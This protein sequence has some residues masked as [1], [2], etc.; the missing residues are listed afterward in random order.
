MCSIYDLVCTAQRAGRRHACRTWTPAT[1]PSQ[2]CPWRAVS[3]FR[4]YRGTCRRRRRL[5]RSSC[6]RCTLASTRVIVK[7]FRS[8]RCQRTSCCPCRAAQMPRCVSESRR[9]WTYSSRIMWCH[10]L[11]VSSRRGALQVA[12]RGLGGLPR[13]ICSAGHTLNVAGSDWY[14]F[15]HGIHCIVLSKE[16]VEL[17]FG[18]NAINSIASKPL[19]ED[20]SRRLHSSLAGKLATNPLRPAVSAP[21]V[22]SRDSKSKELQQ[23]KAGFVSEEAASADNASQSGA[24]A[25]AVAASC[26]SP[27]QHYA[28][29]PKAPVPVGTNATHKFATIAAVC[30]RTRM[31]EPTACP[32]TS[33]V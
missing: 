15:R 26:A 6:A 21:M 33:F 12:D 25:A 29:V 16:S 31:R 13:F 4:K 17:Y 28:V 14:S 5:W 3:P 2:R 10:S 24:V 23:S 18:K 7:R 32:P 27:R 20:L 19:L 30:L 9:C 1:F 22:T 8:P 11:C